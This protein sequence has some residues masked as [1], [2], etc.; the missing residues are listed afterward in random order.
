[1]VNKIARYRLIKQFYTFSDYGSPL[2]GEKFEQVCEHYSQS[3]DNLN[4]IG[5]VMIDFTHRKMNKILPVRSREDET[6]GA[7]PVPK[8][9]IPQVPMAD[10][11]QQAV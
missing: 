9:A 3:A 8:F 6:N 1:M 7:V 2:F 11:A 5:A 4:I 10:S